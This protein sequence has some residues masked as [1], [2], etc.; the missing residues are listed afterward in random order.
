MGYNSSTSWREVPLIL[1]RTDNGV[2]NHFFAKL[3]KAMRRINK[4]IQE[5]F[6]RQLRE[7]KLNVLYKIV[8]ASE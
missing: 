8:E 1:F 3:R 6:R 7:I 4:I 5:K 2:K